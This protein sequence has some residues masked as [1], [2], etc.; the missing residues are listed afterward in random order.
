[1]VSKVRERNIQVHIRRDS[2]GTVYSEVVD[3]CLLNPYFE[4]PTGVVVDRV[5]GRILDLATVQVRA[6]ALAELLGVKLDEDLSW[7]CC[8]H[9]KLACRC[10]ECI[11]AA[12]H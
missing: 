12:G 4:T 3:L 8:A 2:G 5:K 7:P 1:M 11:K 6:K 10:P 9:R